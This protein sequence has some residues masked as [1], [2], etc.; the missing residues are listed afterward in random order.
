LGMEMEQSSEQSTPQ[1]GVQMKRPVPA[2]FVGKNFQPG[3]S[4]NPSGMTA[5]RQ[6]TAE[7]FDEYRTVY[8]R[9]PAA[10]D[11]A[12]LRAAGKLSAK[13]DRVISDEDASRMTRNLNWTLARLGLNGPRATRPLRRSAYDIAG[14]QK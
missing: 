8:G 1:S 11:A 9:E 2:N 12:R 5:S 3:R 14:T 6:R 4:G 7:L 10:S 13:L